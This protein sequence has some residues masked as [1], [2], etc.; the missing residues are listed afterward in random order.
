[1]PN[2]NDLRKEYSNLHQKLKDVEE[3]INQTIHQIHAEMQQCAVNGEIE[4]IVEIAIEHNFP[5]ASKYIRRALSNIESMRDKERRLRALVIPLQNVRTSP[6]LLIRLA[7]AMCYEGYDSC[8]IETIKLHPE[9]QRLYEWMVGYIVMKTADPLESLEE[10]L[11]LVTQWVTTGDAYEA[12]I[13]ECINNGKLKW[14]LAASKAGDY[15]LTDSDLEAIISSNI[16]YGEIS[17][18]E[19]AAELRGRSLTLK[20]VEEAKANKRKIL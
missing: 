4:K 6:K 13:E 20:E 17:E 12:Y 19:A 3:S 10:L 1:M 16:E 2:L 9:P 11:P 7:Q 15:K 8:A 18:A 5:S 14:A